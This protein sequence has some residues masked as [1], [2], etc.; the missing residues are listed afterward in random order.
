M[1]K[2]VKDLLIWL[3]NLEGIKMEDMFRYEGQRLYA[4]ISAANL[5]KAVSIIKEYLTSRLYSEE[6]RREDPINFIDRALSDMPD[7]LA[8]SVNL[9]ML[10]M[11]RETALQAHEEAAKEITAIPLETSYRGKI[12]I[13]RGYRP[14][15]VAELLVE[16]NGEG[17]ATIEIYFNSQCG[18]E[19]KPILWMQYNALLEK[20]VDEGF[21]VDRGTIDQEVEAFKEEDSTYFRTGPINEV[22]SAFDW[23]ELELAVNFLWPEELPQDMKRKLGR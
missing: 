13:T 7:F 10:L 16:S 18:D 11:K 8:Q 5:P 15:N 1:E 9:N 14:G 19:T 21:S 3:K 20:A 12:N 23:S 6:E 2:Q 22:M 17:R 4:D